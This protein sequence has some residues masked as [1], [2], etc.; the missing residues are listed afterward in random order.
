MA[1]LPSPS[2]CWC[3]RS[4]SEP[5]EGQTL[6]RSIL[7]LWPEFAAYLT[8]FA[9]IGII[10]VNHHAVISYA[11]AADR[12]LLALNLV[13]LLF[14]AL[15]PWPTKLIAEYLRAGGEPERTAALVYALSMTLMGV[16]FGAI[17]RYIA[18]RPRLLART[19]SEGEIRARTRRFTLG[20]PIY[21]V[22]ILLALVSAPACLA[23]NALL[24]VYYARPWAARCRRSAR[25]ARVRRGET[26][27][28][29]DSP[30]PVA[31]C[32]A[33][34]S[35]VRVPSTCTGRTPVRTLSPASRSVKSRSR[36]STLARAWS[37]SLV[38]SQNASAA[39]RLATQPGGTRAWAGAT[40][41]DAHPT[42]A[43]GPAPEA[44]GSPRRRPDG[45]P[46]AAE[47]PRAPGRSPPRKTTGRFGTWSPGRAAPTAR[48]NSCRGS[49]SAGGPLTRRVGRCGC[50]SSRR[51]C[52]AATRTG[53]PGGRPR[54]SC[55][56]RCLR[57]PSGRGR[58]CAL[59]KCGRPARRRTARRQP[60]EER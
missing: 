41:R 15:I 47:D 55:R 49:G 2:R 18:H 24:A 30:K 19:L 6:A 34:S 50:G 13:L 56:R 9:V 42:D 45:H 59:R 14:V 36:S 1:S 31:N 39:P 26:I 44:I 53:Q 12:C 37:G 5:E 51:C 11:R 17:W 25:I 3:S 40:P 35:T 10:W 33:T 4:K 29:R 28:Q 46:A 54:S 57:P 58:D 23:V 38:S 27:T 60:Q 43:A 22:S 16:A 20:A 32:P 8:S 48:P 52:K 21:G 7:D